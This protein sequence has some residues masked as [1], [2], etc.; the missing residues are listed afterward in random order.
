MKLSSN[1]ASPDFHEVTLFVKAITID[2]K[3]TRNVLSV[4]TSVGEAVCAYLPLVV[5]RGEIETY[6]EKGE[7]AIVW[8]P[9]SGGQKALQERLYEDWV[10]REEAK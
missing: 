2:G 3:V 7:V 9:S 6:M 10:K 8:A 5:R 1:P 4:D